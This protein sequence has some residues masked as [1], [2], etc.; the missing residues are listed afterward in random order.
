MVTESITSLFKLL[1]VQSPCTL[2]YSEPCA[3][4]SVLRSSTLE[5]LLNLQPMRRNERCTVCVHC[6]TVLLIQFRSH[7]IWYLVML[8]AFDSL[9]LR[10]SLPFKAFS[11]STFC[12]IILFSPDRVLPSYSWYYEARNSLKLFL[13]SNN[14]CTEHLF[15]LSI[16]SSF[17]YHVTFNSCL[18]SAAYR[19]MLPTAAIALAQNWISTLGYFHN[20]VYA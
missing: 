20:S 19:R 11:F 16:E 13:K 6:P 12:V 1:M 10:L 4:C 14:S 5:Y 15:M 8:A 3:Q 2:A 7:L 18:E 9:N 17:T